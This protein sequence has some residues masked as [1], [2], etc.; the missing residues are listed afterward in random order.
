MKKLSEGTSFHQ[1]LLQIHGLHNR[2]ESASEIHRIQRPLIRHKERC[3]DCK[4]H[5]H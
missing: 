1:K 3:R 2:R 4:F 5:K